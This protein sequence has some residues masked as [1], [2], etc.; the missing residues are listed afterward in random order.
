MI[1]QLTCS[2]LVSA[3]AICRAEIGSI[4]SSLSAARASYHSVLEGGP[5]GAISALPQFTINDRFILNQDEGL[6]TLSIETE[7]PLDM[8]VLQCDVPVDLQEVDKSM[9]AVSYTPPDPEVTTLPLPHYL[10]L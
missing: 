1:L 3:L 5:T 7:C 10:L 9:A 4:E 6:Y 8:V 2:S